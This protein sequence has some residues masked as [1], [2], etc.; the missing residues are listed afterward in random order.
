MAALMVVWELAA[1]WKGNSVLLPSPV[2]VLDAIWKLALNLELFEH[3]AIS[4]RDRKS[5]RL[6]SSHTDISRMPSSA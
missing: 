3:A 1:R 5:T 6:N 4:L 2:L